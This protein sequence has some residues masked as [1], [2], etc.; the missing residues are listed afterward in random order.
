MK[1]E[2]VLLGYLVAPLVPPM[3]LLA[4]AQ[5]LPFWD[6]AGIIM[7]YWVFGFAS[8]VVLGTPLLLLYRRLGWTGYVS[9]SIGGGGCA[10]IT[11]LLVTRGFYGAGMIAMWAVTGMVSGVVLRMAL[12]GFRRS[13]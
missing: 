6:A 7:L 9:F 13:G 8:I 2:R 3:I 10:L 4:S 5:K 12:F 11:S 1:I